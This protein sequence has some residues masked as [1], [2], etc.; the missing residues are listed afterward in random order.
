M[1][2]VTSGFTYLDIDAYGGC[3]AYA[4]LLRT[5]GQE[6]IAASNATLNES[7]TQT[8]RNWGGELR[9]NYTAQPDDEFVL[10]DV[11]DLDFFDKFVQQDAVSEIIDHHPGFETYWHER[12][13]DKATIEFIGA[14]CTLVYEK[15]VDAGKLNDMSQTSAR[16]L[17]TG[18]LDNTLNF[19]AHVTTPRD[20]TA[21]EQLMQ[22]ANLSSNWPA[23]YFSECQRA[24]TSKL[25]AAIKNDVKQM[26]IPG[27]PDRIGQLVIWDASTLLQE[28]REEI[29]KIMRAQTG[30]WAM[31]LVSISEGKSYFLADDPEVQANLAKILNVTFT[32]NKATANRLWLRKEIMKAALS[33]TSPA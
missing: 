18:I 4:E 5:Q 13:G 1:K 20:K 24:I 30:T 28:R 21:Y 16:L 17:I 22:R 33:K 29:T 26:D 8:V 19:K 7:I 9:R 2:V 31:N 10:I 27:L 32:E 3:V 11:S 14:A 12:L 6:A 23:E 15:F 25:E